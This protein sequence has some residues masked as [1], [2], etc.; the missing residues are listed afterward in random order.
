MGLTYLIKLVKFFLCN[1]CCFYTTSVVLMLVSITYFTAFTPDFQNGGRPPSWIFI[2]SQY[3]KN[4][5]CAYFSVNMQN[6][7]K[8]GP[9]AAELLLIFDFQNGGRPPSWIWYDVIADHP[10]LVFDGPNILLKLYIDR[11]YTLLDIAIFIFCR[12]GLKLSIHAPFGGGS[13]WGILLP[14]EFRYCC[15]P[16][17]DRPWAKTRRM[18]H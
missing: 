16:Q 5:I 12:F 18:S 11:L 10:R 15:N 8:I 7:V 6:L 4:Q 1:I 3:L 13:F 2:F 14:N 17:K 9:S